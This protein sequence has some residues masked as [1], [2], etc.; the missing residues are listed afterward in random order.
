MP[1][2]F[3]TRRWRETAGRLMVIASAISLTGLSPPLSSR[4][5]SLRLGSPRA[6]NGSPAAGTWATCSAPRLDAQLEPAGELLEGRSQVRHRPPDQSQKRAGVLFAHA[7]RGAAA[8]GRRQL[9]G[10]HTPEEAERKAAAESQ[11]PG[12]LKRRD[13]HRE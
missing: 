4:R 8:C 10:P 2:S 3:S 13:L 11:P 5:I 7:K 6:S 1:A 12:R 9:I